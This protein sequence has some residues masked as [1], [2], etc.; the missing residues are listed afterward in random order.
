MPR[1]RMFVVF[2]VLALVF[3]FAIVLALKFHDFAERDILNEHVRTEMEAIA[4]N[5]AEFG[6]YELNGVPTAHSTPVFPLYLAGIYSIFGTG[7]LA[8]IVKIT[9]TC[10]VSAVRCGLVPLF[11]I[12]AGLDPRVGVLAGGI[13]VLYIGAVQTDISGGVDGP[14]VAIALLI[15]VWAVL[16]MWRDGSWKT[17]TPWL[18]FAFCGFCALLNPNLLP[19]LGAFLLAGGVACPAAARR[20]YLRQTALL[21]LCILVFL[22]PWAIRNY[23]TLGTPILT[24]SNFGLEFWVSNGP[25]R[26]FDLSY[27]YAQ[28]HPSSS[29]IEAKTLVRLGEVE[30]NRLRLTETINWV[31]AYPG[32]FIRLTAQR[33]A[34]WWFPPRPA[35]LLAPLLVLTLLSFTGLWLM[36]RHHP[37]VAWLFLLTWLTFPDVY[38]IVQWTRR[39]RYPMDWQTVLCASVA[40][41]AAYQAVAARSF[42]HKAAG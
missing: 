20:R 30:Y 3:R 36:F 31:R 16:R 24:R 26:T 9:L 22:M 10:A 8:Q 38:Y 4:F 18:F 6:S 29:P 7:L 15:L 5:V 28:F 40:L 13:S 12:D 41:F 1:R 34:A 19:V 39:Y 27:D 42:G 35:I 25:G 14:F 37:L 23:W 33:F 21:V 11:A 32:E 17:R 2:F